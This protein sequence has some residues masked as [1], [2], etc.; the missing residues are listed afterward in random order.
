MARLPKQFC[1]SIPL[2]LLL[3]YSPYIDFCKNMLPIDRTEIM[4]Q[5]MG[6]GLGFYRFGKEM[7]ELFA[8]SDSEFIFR[9]ERCTNFVGWMT[10]QLQLC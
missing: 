3:P 1:L 2:Y 6:T 9:V 5:R 8:S 4:K 10:L 7:L